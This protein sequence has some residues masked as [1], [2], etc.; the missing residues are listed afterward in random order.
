VQ[1]ASASDDISIDHLEEFA[2]SF[3]ERN[4][5]CRVPSRE[6]SEFCLLFRRELVEKIGPFDESLGQN[7]LE[8]DDICLRAAL[9]GHINL[10]VGDVFVYKYDVPKFIGNKKSFTE[11]W[12]GIDAQSPLGKKLLTLNAMEKA[13]ELDEKGQIDDAIRILVQGTAHVPDDKRLYHTLSEMLINNKQYKEALDA[14]NELPSDDQDVKKLELT[15]YCMEG[16][17]QFK[18]AEEYADHAL[19]LDA[20]SALALNLKGVL[21]YRQGDS[22]MA[23]VFFNRAITSDPGFGEP[24]TN[25]GALKWAMGDQEEALELYERGFILSPTIMDI[26]TIYHSTVTELGE[27]ERAEPVF[28]DTS[29][30]HPYNRRLKYLLID[31]YI[32][33]GKHD[34]A[35]EEIEGAMTAFGIDDGLLSAALKVR[36]ALGPEK[37]NEKSNRKDTI[38]LCMIVKNEEQHLAKCLKSVKPVVDE[39]IVVDTGSTDRTRDIARIFGA[40]VYDIEWRDDFSEARNYS[41]SKASGKWILVMDADEVISPFDYVALRRLVKKST[42][43]SVAYSFVTRNYSTRANTIGWTVN[44]GKYGMEEAGS[45]WMPST[46]VRLFHNMSHI[47]FEYPVHEKVEPALKRSGIEIK[48]C[49]TPVHH[50]GQLNEKQFDLKGEAYYDMGRKKLEKLGDDV[51]AIRELA[52]QAGGLGKHD[53]AIE[54]WQRLV[55]IKPDMPVAYVNMGT[56]YLKL[57]KYEEALLSA[58]KAV[59]FDPNMKEAL[60]NYALCQLY[61]G[62]VRQAIPALEKLMEQEP[63]YLSAQFVLAAAYCCD[64]KMKR[65]LETFEKLRQTITGPGLAVACHDLAKKLVSAQRLEYAIL[66][67]EAAIEGKYVNKDVL[68]LLSECRRTEQET[69]DCIHA[70]SA[71]SN[72]FRNQSTCSSR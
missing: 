8:V 33:Q 24:Y 34:L 54:L 32:Q 62:N 22:S 9:D 43:R 40:R 46:K 55:A 68:S 47:R 58:K 12:N 49:N 70:S 19:S 66:L 14:L 52:V 35:M 48:K 2:K 11:K 50:Y 10:I 7:N 53:E 41:I 67:L 59:E 21:A 31:I 15:G 69:M 36:E 23:E 63:E 28:R 61:L 44:D 57:G 38:S 6:L 1:K 30:L 72:E 42:S 71:L 64:G 56:A 16:M 51:V 20:A 39:M 17:E 60:N 29:A 5:Y 26:V 13:I 27:F 3:R 18:E 4:R 37:I 25:L 65:G 45:G